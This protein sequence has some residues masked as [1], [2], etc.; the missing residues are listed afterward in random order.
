MSEQRSYNLHIDALKT[1]LEKQKYIYEDIDFT[2]YSRKG[3][4][5]LALKWRNAHTLMDKNVEEG[6]FVEIECRA[7]PDFVYHSFAL[8]LVY[9]KHVN[10]IF[11]VEVYPDFKLSHREK[12]GVEIYGS[13]IHNLYNTEKINNMNYNSDTWYD[14]LKYFCNATNITIQGR[15]YE[16]IISDGLGL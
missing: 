2:R 15:H 11:Q 4:Y 14:W 5:K 10:I 8:Q 13:H 12:G 1:F 7:Y 16:P 3:S 6:L 9:K